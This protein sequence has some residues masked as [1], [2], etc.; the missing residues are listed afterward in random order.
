VDADDEFEDVS[1]VIAEM[2]ATTPPFSLRSRM[3]NE[4]L[5]QRAA[6]TEHTSPI[7]DGID[8]YRRAVGELDSI[9]DQLTG[10]QQMEVVAHRW[11]V[12]N[13]LEHLRIVD[14]LAAATLH[15]DLR[16]DAT[17]DIAARTEDALRSPMSFERARETWHQQAGELLDASSTCDAQLVHYLGFDLDPECVIVDRAFETWLH[18]QDIRTALGLSLQAPDTQDL[19]ALTNLGSHML[20]KVVDGCGEGT[21][22][23][24]LDGAGSWIVPLAKEDTGLTPIATVTLDA[25]DFCLLIGERL[26]FDDLR[27]TVDGDESAA[28]AM[29]SRAPLLARL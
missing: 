28:V 13:V 16:A 19:A 4:A 24:V 18:T 25:V 22:R 5:R 8:T 7:S 15:G 20:A 29:L 26:T 9:V 27:F 6:S 1:T 14:E 12:A 21:V 23:M 17:I 2:H 11:N 10:E 3:M